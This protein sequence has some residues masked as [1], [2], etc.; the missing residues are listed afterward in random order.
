MVEPARQ[1][2]DYA[3][4]CCLVDQLGQHFREPGDVAEV[5]ADGRPRKTDKVVAV[6]VPLP[7]DTLQRWKAKG[8][9]RRTKMAERLKG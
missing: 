6:T 4:P 7:P 9:D 3:P 5:Q 8:D 2:A 1:G